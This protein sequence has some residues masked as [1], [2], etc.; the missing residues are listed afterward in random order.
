MP[1]KR[2]YRLFDALKRAELMGRRRPGAP[3][4]GDYPPSAPV[5]HTKPEWM[6]SRYPMTP[7]APA[8]SRGAPS[9]EPDDEQAAVDGI[10]PDAVQRGIAAMQERRGI[11]NRASQTR[12]EAQ[13]AFQQRKMAA[14]RA[15][16]FRAEERRIAGP[17]INPRQAAMRATMPYQPA[18][19]PAST[20]FGQ[21]AASEMASRFGGAGVEYEDELERFRPPEDARTMLELE[22]KRYDLQRGKTEDIQE[23]ENRAFKRQYEEKQNNLAIK[24]DEL[25]IRIS[26]RDYEGGMTERQAASL[27]LVD[28]QVLALS[29]RANEAYT[30]GDFL[31]GD[32]LQDKINEL[33]NRQEQIIDGDE[34]AVASDLEVE[35][36]E[37]QYLAE[38]KRSQ[39]DFNRLAA[40]KSVQNIVSVTGLDSA[41]TLLTEI[42]GDKALINDETPLKL[43]EINQTIREALAHAAGD[44]EM[45]RLIRQRIRRSV[46][47][48]ETQ[49]AGK[50]TIGMVLSARAGA[51]VP[52][53]G[54]W[55]AYKGI[56]NT[57]KLRKEVKEFRRLMQIGEGENAKE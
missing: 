8:P 51:G 26:E 7:P 40:V 39:E 44:A 12:Q 1:K 53:V 48:V 36:F 13:Q 15:R 6:T 37:S 19:Q 23:D 55:L 35:E 56:M 47:F 24:R 20:L 28:R 50:V 9:V 31:T 25:Q 54:W 46:G 16:L 43:A 57:R 10:R 4:P 49:T 5:R 34:T 2:G 27:E 30:A 29:E 52:V 45:E 11:R 41:V 22:Q 17:R 21:R 3:D 14:E 33:T 32:R 18:P 42:G 38:R